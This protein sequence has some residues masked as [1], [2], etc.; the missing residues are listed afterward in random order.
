[1][2]KNKNAFLDT[3]RHSCAHVMAE[4]VQSLYKGTKL[5][6]GPSIE[7]GFYYDFESKHKFVPEDL[8]KIEKKMKEIIKSRE[9]FSCH[10]IS[11][12]KAVEFFTKRGEKFKLDLIKELDK[13]EDITYYEHGDFVDLC[14]GPHLEHTGQIKHFK[15]THIA[16]AYW[17]GDEKNKMLQRIYGICF[18]DKGKLNEYLTQLE[19]AKKRD[20]R[21]IGQELKLFSISEDIGPG[22]ILWHPKGGVIRT[23]LQ[24]WL[25][26]ENMRRGY[27]IVYTPHIARRGLWETSGHTDFYSENMFAPMEIDNQ[28]YQIKPMNC[29]F[30]IG[31]YKNE[32]RSYRDLPFKLSELGTVYRYERSGVLHG[33]LRVRGFTL[34]DAH[35]FCTPEQIDKEVQDSIDF[36]IFIMKTFGFKDYKVELSIWDEKNPKK[37]V[38]T[39]KD[40]NMAQK[41]LESVLKKRKIPYKVEVGEAAFYGPKI[42][43]KL[44]DAIK[45]TWQLSTIQFDFNL[46]TRFKLEYV[47]EKGRKKPY[48]VHRALFG[49]I[50]RFV[51]ILIEHYAGLFPLWLNPV[52]VKI[53]TLTDKEEKYAKKLAEKLQAKGVRVEM[54][55]RPEKL[56]LKIR[57]T[58]N[59][60]VGYTAIIGG[61]EAKENKVAVRLRNGK[62]QTIKLDDFLAKVL[63]EIENKDLEPTIK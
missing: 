7:N 13:N 15:L 33:L 20:H 56:S 23:T 35:I 4:A 46:P 9:K 60:K 59:Q 25:E 2:V 39:K 22:L 55:L 58:H 40:W 26:D 62:N 29:P 44:V 50:E 27:K 63:K 41:S 11:K 52:Q 34:D 16:G 48:M 36:V 30:H 57:E 1:M 10:K 24:R 19:E 12:R 54:D 3:M 31:I 18:Q 5:G 51:G 6:I 49:S 37:Y 47:A 8:P 14:K 61:R 43:I 42:D 45:R 21:K 17:R 38:G 32:L 28:K 53:L